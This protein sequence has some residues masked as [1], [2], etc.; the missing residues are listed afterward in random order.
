M[1]GPSSL[2]AMLH[3]LSPRERTLVSAALALVLIT[4]LIYGVMMPGMAAARSAANR[5]A[6]ATENLGAARSLSASLSQAK[7][8]TTLD[9][10][11]QSAEANGLAIVEASANADGVMMRVRSQ[12][13]AS[14]LAWL[15][16]SRGTAV[17]RTIAIEP[18]PSGGVVGSIQ[19][20]GVTP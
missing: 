11:R 3:R 17:M 1:N 19:Y 7:A 14:I 4:G 8:A 18:D 12:G 16:N 20:T 9:T 5:N 2:I 13:P 10:L 15:A 6:D